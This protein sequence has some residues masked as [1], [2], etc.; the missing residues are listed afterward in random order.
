M[1]AHPVS[2]AATGVHRPSRL[3]INRAGLWLFLLSESFLFTAILTSRYYLQGLAVNQ[4]VNQI[5]GLGITIVL[6]LSSL[7]AYR[8]EMCAAHGDMKGAS[9]NLAFTIVLGLIFV[10][11][12]GLEWREAF[13]H[14]PPQTAFGTLFFT[15]TG[16]HAFHVI[17]G[18]LA[19]GVVYGMVRRGRFTGGNYWGVE[20][21]VKYWHF[22]DV[23]WVFIYQTLYLVN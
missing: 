13:V 8:G 4:D 11:G 3:V 16:I 21:V 2:H 15:M 9:R 19:L 5:L 20:G 18:L 10:V 17:T 14:F 12:V 23:A 1:A 6:L 22:V 7:S